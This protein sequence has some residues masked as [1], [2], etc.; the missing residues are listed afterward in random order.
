AIIWPVV[1]SVVDP[2]VVNEIDTHR[3]WSAQIKPIDISFTGRSYTL[4][5]G[6]YVG[7]IIDAPRGMI[8]A[9]PVIVVRCTARET[10][11]GVSHTIFETS[12]AR[13]SFDDATQ[14]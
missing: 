11:I 12:K 13:L 6:E 4:G 1:S 3:K 9:I 2:Y 14:R 7:C 8:L 10:K 5:K